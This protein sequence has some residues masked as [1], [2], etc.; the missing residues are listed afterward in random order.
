MDPHDGLENFGR[1]CDKVQDLL[2]AVGSFEKGKSPYGAYDKTGNAEEW[3]VDW[4]RSDPD[5]FGSLHMK[6]ELKQRVWKNSLGP[7]NW[8]NKVSAWWWRTAWLSVSRNL[9][10]GPCGSA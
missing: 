7:K 5:Y 6:S 9:G 2:A 3:V 10:P 8:T 4:S 1:C